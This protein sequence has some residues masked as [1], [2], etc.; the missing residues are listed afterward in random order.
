MWSERIVVAAFMPLRCWTTFPHPL[1]YSLWNSNYLYIFYVYTY[2]DSTTVYMYMYVLQICIL[3][4]VHV[5]HVSMYTCTVVWWK[6]TIHVHYTCTYL[7]L[8]NFQLMWYLHACM[9]VY[10]YS[11]RSESNQSIHVH[12]CHIRHLC[13]S[14]QVWCCDS[15]ESGR[16]H[17]IYTV[18]AH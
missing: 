5:A 11:L 15:A 1:S 7:F 6:C 16:H 14:G 3:Y 9:H 13:S 8:S 17:W 10:M 4:S 18:T 2:T 12:V